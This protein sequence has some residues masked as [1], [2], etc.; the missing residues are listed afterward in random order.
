MKCPVCG[1]TDF[2]LK[3]D[4]DAF[5]FSEFHIENGE[6]IFEDEPMEMTGDTPTHCGK[7]AWHGKFNQLSKT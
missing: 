6:C 3:D 7:C 5:A 4:H 2:Y 1:A